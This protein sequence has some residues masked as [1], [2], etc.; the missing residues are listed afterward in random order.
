MG[1][2]PEHVLIATLPCGIRVRLGEAN[3]PPWLARA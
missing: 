2:A 3:S 1:S